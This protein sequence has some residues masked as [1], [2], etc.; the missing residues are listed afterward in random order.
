MYEVFE[1]TADLGLRMQARDLNCLF[2][3]AGR[4]L[5]SVIVANL[6]EVQPRQPA[7]YQVKGSELD[8]LLLDWLNELLFTFET[9]RILFS[10]FQVLVDPEGLHAVARGE[11]VEAQRHRL[12]HEVKAITYHNLRV[13]HTDG[14]WEAEVIVDI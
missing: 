10:E 6:D 3:E 8:Y 1:H 7:E 11:P 14:G 9:Q 13:A 5:F 2:A 12:D 4:A